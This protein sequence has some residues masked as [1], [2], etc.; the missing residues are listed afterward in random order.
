HTPAPLPL[1]PPPRPGGAGKTRLAVEAARA[2]LP[3][4]PDGVW[5]VELAPVTDPPDVPSAV[6][7]TLGLREQALVS[8]TRARRLTPEAPLPPDELSRLVSALTGK[9]ALLVLDNCEHLIAAGADPGDRIL[10]A[11]P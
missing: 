11:C 5:L 2:E 9:R 6:L 10:A 4:M 1:D 8:S 3:A 7:S